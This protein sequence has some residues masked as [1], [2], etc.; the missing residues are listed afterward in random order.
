MLDIELLKTSWFFKERI[1]LKDEILFSQWE[2]DDNLYIVLDG[3]LAVEKYIS[4][5]NDIFKLL[6]ILT[7]WDIF[8]EWSLTQKSNKEV[9]VRAITLCHILSIDAMFDFPA[10]VKSQPQ[11]AYHLLLKIIELSNKRLLEANSQL[12][13]H[14]E[15]SKAISQMGKIDFKSIVELLEIF[16]SIL[17]ADSIIYIEKNFALDGYYKIRYSSWASEK[18][19]NTII[20]L[21]SN[22]LRPEYIKNNDLFQYE[23][24]LTVEL[25]LWNVS[26]WFLLLERNK[27]WFLE[28]EERL[29]QNIATSFVGVIHQKHLQDEKRNML[30]IKEYS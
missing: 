30:H 14:Y 21:P 20:E 28:Q 29:L 5:K 9:Q 12:T 11:S 8:W 4:S 2:K 24:F 13:A 17:K 22:I 3:E 7:H 18:I 16:Q 6:N 27:K 1:L 25:L 23:Y 15:I 19:Q 10:F 26:Y